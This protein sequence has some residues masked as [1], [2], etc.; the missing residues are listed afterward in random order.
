V[1]PISL[2]K[3]II[4]GDAPVTVLDDWE[5][6]VRTVLSEWLPIVENAIPEYTWGS[7]HTISVR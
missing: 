7:K 3:K 5:M 2:I 4:D 6:I 1:I